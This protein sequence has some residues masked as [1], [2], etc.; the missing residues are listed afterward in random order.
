MG[1]PEWRTKE[2]KGRF[3]M[4][5]FT[6]RDGSMET[7]R[8]WL[9]PRL[10]DELYE[11]ED[12]EHPDVAVAHESGWSVSLFSSGTIVLE[13]VEDGQSQPVHAYG[14]RDE[15]LVAAT[16]VAAGC[17]ELLADWPWLPGYG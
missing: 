13:N 16:A 3:S 1:D 12:I 15:Q 8:L 2:L 14:G 11:D 17:A 10:I 9:L 4:F 5:T 7:G 6:N